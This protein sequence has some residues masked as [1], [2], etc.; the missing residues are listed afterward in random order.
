MK[1][2]PILAAL[3][4]LTGCAHYTPQPL[5]ADPAVLAAPVAAVLQARAS[6]ID[7]PWLTPTSINLAAPLTPDGLAAIAVVNNPDLTALRARAGVGDAQV[8]A[9][10]LL[11][12][13][14]FSLGADTII[15]GPDHLLSTAGALGL[16]LGALRSRAVTRERARQQDRQ[17]RLDLAWAEWQMAGQARLLGVRI[18][19]LEAQLALAG[20]SRGAADGL[21]AHTAAAARRGDIAGGDTTAA[22]IAAFD[23]AE[24][25]RANERDLLTARQALNRALGLPPAMPIQLAPTALPSVPQTSEVLF[26]LARDRRTDLAALRAGYASQEAAVHKAVLDQFPNL[27]LTINGSRDST[28]NFLLGPS[29]GF[30]LPLWN[31]N[32]GGIAVER[33]TRE[34]VRA[35]YDAR[36]FQTRADITDAAAGIALAF[37]QRGDAQASL[38]ELRRHSDASRRAAARGDIAPAQAAASEQQLRDRL[39]LIAQSEQTIR[40]QTI[41]LELLSGEPGGA[42]KP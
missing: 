31:R 14:S 41:A 32:R 39:I 6:A 24:R 36:L 37:R 23:A 10:G 29:L 34:A 15:N 30:T 18:V 38:P 28:G 8:F 40:E 2:V 17:L 42:P 11:P 12:D 3:L 25:E 5:T 21:L 27:S 4:G 13:P 35:E 1:V 20:Q 22:R 26:A 16:D 19:A 7:R 33:A 9:A